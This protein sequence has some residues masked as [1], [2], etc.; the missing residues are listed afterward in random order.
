[1]GGTSTWLF[2][3]ALCDSKRENICVR[4]EEEEYQKKNRPNHF[5]HFS[6]FSLAFLNR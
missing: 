1:V 3:V 5:F 4:E 2:Y 6:P